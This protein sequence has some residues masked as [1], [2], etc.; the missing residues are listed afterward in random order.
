VQPEGENPFHKGV[1]RYDQSRLVVQTFFGIQGKPVPNEG[2]YVRIVI[3]FSPT[4]LNEGKFGI[5][6]DGT[7]V[8]IKD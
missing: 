2:G 1:Q 4:G 7:A 8:R 5:R 3:K 6:P